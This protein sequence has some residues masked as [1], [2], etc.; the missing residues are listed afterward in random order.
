MLI[1]DVALAL[2]QKYVPLL[3]VVRNPAL[4]QVHW[5]DMSSTAGFDLTPDAGTTFRKII[6]MNLLEDLEK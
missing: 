5:D 2:L 1:A 6:R 4:R 3:T